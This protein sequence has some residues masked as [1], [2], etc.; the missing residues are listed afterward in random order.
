MHDMTK[1][2]NIN[3]FVK[4]LSSFSNVWISSILYKPIFTTSRENMFSGFPMIWDSNQ[5]AQLQRLASILKFHLK[6]V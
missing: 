1:I 6:Q 5:P 4:N 3:D 2:S